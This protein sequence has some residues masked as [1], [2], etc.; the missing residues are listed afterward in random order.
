M[1]LLIAALFLPLHFT[2]PADSLGFDAWG[3][4]LLSKHPVHAY[5]FRQLQ[6]DGSTRAILGYGDS[7][8]RSILVPHTPGT[9]ETAWFNAPA[10]GGIISIYVVSQDSNGNT[11]APSNACALGGR[12]ARMIPARAGWSGLEVPLVQQTPEHCGQAALQM[13]LSYYGAG[14][15]ALREADR[16]Y[17]PVLRGSLIT[18]LALAAR[19][20]GYEAVVSTLTADS[21][22][23]LLH[24]GVPPIL[25]YQNGH[26]PL[27]VRHFGVVTGW[28]AGRASF[29]LHDGT[30]HERVAARDDLEKRW[31]TAGSQALVVRRLP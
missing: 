16:A 27:T 3:R 25:L 10:N 8:G 7:A 31:E 26:G 24:L 5:L 4:A 13:V 20:A 30:A 1:H 29:T 23:E 21:L 11:S 6:A 17:D 2:A 12:G 28:D 19:R 14:P 22:V 15:A 18:D 9:R